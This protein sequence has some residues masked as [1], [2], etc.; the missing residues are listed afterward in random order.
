[1]DRR[2]IKKLKEGQEFENYKEICKFLCERERKGRAKIKQLSEWELYFSFTRIGN[3]YIINKTHEN[4]I[5][6]PINNIISKIKYI[7]NLEELIKQLLL[8]NINS[9]NISISKHKLFEQLHMININYQVGKH[10]ILKL[11]QYI[12]IPAD[13]IEEFYRS[14]NDMFIRN[15][16]NVLS[17]LS[18]Q[19]YIIWEKSIFLCYVDT[20]VEK[21]EENIPK[22]DVTKT[23][24][25]END[26]EYNC[27]VKTFANLIHRKA[28]EEEKQTILRVQQET[29]LELNCSTKQEVVRVGKWND[30]VKKANERLL[31][32]SNILYFYN[33]YDITY[34]KE[35]IEKMEIKKINKK[36][37]Q[38]ELNKAISKRIIKNTK[39]R[40][41]R[42]NNEPIENYIDTRKES[43]Y[44]RRMKKKY[45]ENNKK[46]TKIMIDR[47]SKDIRKDIRKQK[48]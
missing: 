27:K 17:K 4:K 18:Q 21:N 11:S 9:E 32:I 33:C 37:E 26:E 7:N 44:L 12:D 34:N 8:D 6:Q 28:T 20:F 5:R 10:N 30:F 25:K 40:Y 35:F 22:A 46:L 29:M 23:I 16:E 42:A 39:A 13:D 24:N 47:K 41:N 3:K 31:D 19:L 2:K 15:V 1:M 14:T 45:I 38:Q 36:I 43:T 48:I